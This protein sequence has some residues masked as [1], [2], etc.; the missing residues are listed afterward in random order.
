MRWT[1]TS[2]EEVKICRDQR[3]IL[4]L[5]SRGVRLELSIR[6]S[7]HTDRNPRRRKSRIWSSV[8][9]KLPVI[10]STRRYFLAGVAW[11]KNGQ[12]RSDIE[13]SGGCAGSGEN[14]NCAKACAE[15]DPVGTRSGFL[16][17]NAAESLPELCLRYPAVGTRPSKCCTFLSFLSLLLLSFEM[18]TWFQCQ[19]VHYWRK[20]SP[21]HW[22]MSLLFIFTQFNFY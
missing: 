20:W 10:Q 2:R 3:S 11:L 13:A 15:A 17:H 14:E 5:I 19:I 8:G 12:H 22:I 6:I 1:S 16:L 9:L 21:T 18:A 4:C 7:L